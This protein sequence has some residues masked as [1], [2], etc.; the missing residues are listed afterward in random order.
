MSATKDGPYPSSH[1]LAVR[2]YV[3]L[4]ARNTE[5]SQGA[6]RLTTNAS[7]LAVLSLKLSQAF[8]QA[9]REVERDFAQRE[10]RLA[11]RYAPK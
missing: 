2:I 7:N 10:A 6:V 8:M 4:V 3:E 1:D 5:V 9:V 11:A